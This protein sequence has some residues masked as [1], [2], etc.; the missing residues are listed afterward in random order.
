MAAPRR[1][2]KFFAGAMAVLT[3]LISAGVLKA[4]AVRKAMEEYPVTFEGAELPTDPAP[5]PASL[6]VTVT[7]EQSG[8]V[9]AG[10]IPR[11]K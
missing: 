9:W 3:M 10:S 6:P 7:V 4:P 5:V 11:V 1:Q 8:K 2:G